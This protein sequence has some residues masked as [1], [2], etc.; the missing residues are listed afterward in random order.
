LMLVMKLLKNLGAKYIM[1]R[2]DSELVIK[3]PKVS[4]QLNIL[5]S[6]CIEIFLWIFYNVSLKLTCR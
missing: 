5:D 3:K 2:E 4:I 6:E 1:V